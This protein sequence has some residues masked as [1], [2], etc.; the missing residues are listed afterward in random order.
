MLSRACPDSARAIISSALKVRIRPSDSSMVRS[1]A[2]RYSASLP[3]LARASSARLPPPARGLFQMVSDFVGDFFDPDHQ[4][5]NP[6]QHRV[7]FSREP[8]ELVAAAP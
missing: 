6:L 8:I 4:G 3:D 7:G 1:R 5:F 2:E